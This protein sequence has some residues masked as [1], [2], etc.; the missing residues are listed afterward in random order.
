VTTDGRGVVV[1]VTALPTGL[2]QIVAVEDVVD[3]AICG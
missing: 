1:A 3:A 2:E